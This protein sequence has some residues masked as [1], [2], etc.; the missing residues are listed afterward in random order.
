MKRTFLLLII[1]SISGWLMAQYPDPEFANEVYLLKKDSV[2]VVRLEKGTSGMDTKVKLAGFG[3]VESGYVLE[4]EKSD[5]RLNS[6]ASLSFVFSTGGAKQRNAAADSAM[7]ANGMD[8]T[9]MDEMMNSRTDPSNAISL[10]K[11]DVGKGKR[12]VLL[13]KSGPALP[14]SKKGGSSTKYTFSV[15]KI[16]EGYWELIVDKTLPKG[17]YVFTYQGG[18]QGMDQSMLLFAF[19]VN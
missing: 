11:A 14:F 1:S 8:P 10:Y 12:K 7:R 9:Q 16:R 2:R 5:V 15:K 19:A 17:E 18:Q 3:G 4:G 6:G 13:A